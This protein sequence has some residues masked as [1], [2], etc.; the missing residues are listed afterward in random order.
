[1]LRQ[2]PQQNRKDPALPA[3]LSAVLCL[4]PWIN[5]DPFAENYTGLFSAKPLFTWLCMGPALL[6]LSILFVRSARRV[7]A[8][9][10]ADG[11]SAGLFL[12][13]LSLMIITYKKE[14]DLSTNLHLILAY[15]L[16]ICLNLVLYKI[17]EGRN[18]LMV[19]YI[20]GSLTAFFTAL[21]SASVNGMSEIIYGLTLIITLYLFLNRD[22]K[23][24]SE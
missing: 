2:P 15:A 12:L 13:V 10:Q 7:F 24:R 16:L 4:L 19:F 9:K 17:L 20:C 3:L 1:M 22:N 21:L 8:W 5:A 11:I 23:N 14:T 6:C 18:G